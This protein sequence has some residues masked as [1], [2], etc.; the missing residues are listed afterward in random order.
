MGQLTGIEPH[1]AKKRSSHNSDPKT[2]EKDIENIEWNR[3]LQIPSGDPTLSF[4]IFL[5]KID[6]FLD[7]HRT[8]K[9]PFKRKLRTKSKSYD[10]FIT[11]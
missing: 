2:F 4:Q 8:F 10:K 7:K 1:K 9:K 3:T 5:S 11:S 6:N